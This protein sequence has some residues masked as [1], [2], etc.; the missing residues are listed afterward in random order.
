MKRL[1]SSVVLVVA[2]AACSSGESGEVRLGVSV[3]HLDTAAAADSVAAREAAGLEITRVR[4]LVNTAKV[5]YAGHSDGETTAVGPIVVELSADEVKSGAQR[6][7]TIGDLDTGTYG[8]AEIEVDSL[9]AKADTSDASLA[10][11]ATTGASV[12]VDGT[13]GERPSSSPA[14]SSPSKAPMVK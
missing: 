12:L 5:G 11:F 8:G 7:F 4:I 10:D 13:Y 6:S 2:I 1:F 14:T 9:D 3:A